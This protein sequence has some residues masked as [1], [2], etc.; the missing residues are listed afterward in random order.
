MRVLVIGTSGQVATELHGAPCPVD[1][2]LLPPQKI[3]IGHPEHLTAFLDAARPDVV[4]NAAAYTAVDRAETEPELAF[5]VNSDGPR[6]LAT[7]CEARRAAL[8][9][10]S[11][12]YV[13]DGHKDAPYVE[14]DATKPLNVY[15]R[16]KLAGEEAI[17]SNLARHLIIRTSWV[18]SSHG[19]NFVKTILRLARERDELRVV[20][21]Q[22]GRPTA[23]R[24]LATALVKLCGLLPSGSD[25][26]GT[27]HLANEGEA[28]W[29]RFARVVVERQRAK[30]GREPQVVPIASADYP[31]PAERPRNSVLDVT[32]FRKT[33]GFGLPPWQDSLGHVVDEL[34]MQ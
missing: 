13:F 27:Y 25:G 32:R 9:H 3:D 6:Y 23:A 33:F 1:V 8:I 19:S 16:S 20:A 2:S 12:D 15:G 28:T 11:T 7:W 10:L 4:I 31:T 17:R 34:L 21:D 26:W 24:D 30:T 5:R 29:H 14:T 22:R 18:F